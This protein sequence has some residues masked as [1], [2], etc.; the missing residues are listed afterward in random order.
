MLSFNH[1]KFILSVVFALLATAF[2]ASAQSKPDGPCTPVTHANRLYTVCEAP[3]NRYSIALFWQRPDGQPYNY[4]NGLPPTQSSGSRLAFALNA[5]MFDPNYKPVGLYVEAGREMTRANTNAGSGNFHLKPNGIFYIVGNEA[6]VMETTAFLKRNL[7]VD[8]AT[9]SG[10]MLVI[11]GRLHPRIATA[12]AS[13]KQRDG[14][15]VRG[16]KVVIFVISEDA[17]SFADFQRLFRDRLKC[18][19][20]L[21]LDGGSA[22]ALHIPADRR[23]GNS[24]VALGPMIGVYEKL[25]K[26]KQGP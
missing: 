22:P 1:Y 4:L 10:P 17:V 26:A 15:C 23:T 16:G 21:F 19:D 25:D 20:A 11:D 13:E 9:Q 14:V 12:R 2:G 6:G 5:G 18:R 24:F 3:L 8:Y 7:K